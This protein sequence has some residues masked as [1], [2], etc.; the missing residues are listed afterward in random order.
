MFNIPDKYK[1][2][3]KI[4][5]KVFIKKD[6]KQVEKKKLKECLKS[7][8]LTYQLVGEEI[9]SI[10]NENY[11][12]QVI[13]FLEVEI[14]NIKNATFVGE[15]IQEEI[16]PLC[17]IR[18]FDSSM[19]R[20]YFAE[21][22]LNIQDTSS[23]VIENKVITDE[24]SIFFYENWVEKLKETLDYNNVILRENKLFFYREM[25][26]KAFIISN[27]KLSET[28]ENLLNSNLWYRNTKVKSLL[29][30][31]KE[32]E[33]LKLQLKKTKDTKE[34]VKINKELKVLNEKILDLI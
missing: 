11:N 14:D 25:M 9:P 5:T 3:Q 27:F 33:R 19:E 29:I 20:Y 22:R 34:K 2:N 23:I 8:V 30:Y 6:L 12:C 24:S 1:V 26:V 31:L 21:K 4:D 18:I 10:I 17:I 7:I 16:K 32:I 15:I 28:N 13:M